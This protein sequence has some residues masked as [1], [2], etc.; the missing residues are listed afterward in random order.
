[1]VIFPGLTHN[2]F[3]F[4]SGAT[5]F[6]FYVFFATFLYHHLFF[7]YFTKVTTEFVCF[8][9]FLPHTPLICL[10]KIEIIFSE[11]VSLYVCHVPTYIYSNISVYYGCTLLL[12][13][14]C[15]INISGAI[16]T[17]LFFASDPSLSHII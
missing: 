9:V 12:K 15:R 16:D 3:L 14:Y 4:L 7:L 11:T 10:L 1:M 5:E 13:L 17:E 8:M 2:T 6:S